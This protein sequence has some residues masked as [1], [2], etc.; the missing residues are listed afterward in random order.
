M[1]LGVSRV[2]PV[3]AAT[4]PTLFIGP[5]SRPLATAGSLV[6][7]SVNFSSFPTFN[8]YDIQVQADQSILNPKSIDFNGATVPTLATFVNCV[9]GGAGFPSGSPGNQGCTA[10]DGPG[11]AHAAASLNGLPGGNGL[12]FNVNFTAVSSPN[13][14]VGL[15]N[16]QVSDAKGHSISHSSMNGLYGKPPGISISATS[17]PPIQVGGSA[18]ST[19]TLGSLPDTADVRF[20]GNAIVAASSNIAGVSASPSPSTHTLFAGMTNSYL[21]IIIIDPT[22]SASKANITLTVL[23]NDTAS[24]FTATNSTI[25]PVSISQSGTVGGIT[26]PIDKL[27]LIS[28]YLGLLL[29]IVAIAL[30]SMASVKYGI[31]RR[32]LASYPGAKLFGPKLLEIL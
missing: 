19:V 21:L 3:H 24:G 29:S 27:S 10:S 7:Y 17:P 14:L 6:R 8:G 32:T 23:G 26:I 18:T 13:S 16:D 20:A 11:I 9:N 12:L 30:A 1:F 15:R 31:R 28:P 22:V 25:L 5:A 2:S 4:N